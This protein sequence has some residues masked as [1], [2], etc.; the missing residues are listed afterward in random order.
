MMG[1]PK[2]IKY[3]FPLTCLLLAALVMAACSKQQQE[4]P[5]NRLRIVTTV[6]PL[7][8]YVR[9]IGGNYVDAQLLLPPG[10]EAHSFEPKPEEILRVSRADLFVFTNREMEPWADKLLSAVQEDRKPL[11]VEAGARALYLAAADAHGHDEHGHGSG[12]RDA[13]DP[14][15][16]LNIANAKLMVDS[17]AEAMSG[18]LPAGRDVF[19]ANAA[20]YKKRLDD[21]DI[22]F[23]DGLSS[24]RT[25]EFIHSGHYAF[26]YLADRYKLTY[27][28]AYGITADSEPS[29][30]RMMELVNSIRTHKLKYI[31]FEEL[32]A[33]RIAETISR[34]TGAGLLK[35]HGI[36][37]L[38]RDELESGA[39][40]LGLMEQNLA[41]LRKGLECR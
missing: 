15:I 41:N 22:R 23:Q 7:Y 25:R 27:V 28:S 3:V 35:L 13:R 26:A 5:G 36:H 24:C 38:T 11:Q 29:P 12:R 4:A 2:G 31:F 9:N 21:L 20:T 39:S 30:R 8:D 1:K 34:E 6:F 16:W 18:R 40:Y 14:H 17:I 33:P 37:N 10:V 32:L 19:R